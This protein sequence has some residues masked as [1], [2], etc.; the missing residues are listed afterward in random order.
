[1]RHSATKAR[2]LPQKKDWNA[3]M[4]SPPRIA[5]LLLAMAG[6]AAV[7]ALILGIG[8]A[9]DRH[10]APARGPVLGPDGMPVPIA[11]GAAPPLPPVGLSHTRLDLAA[12]FLLPAPVFKV[13]EP[14]FTA[15]GVIVLLYAGVRIA[16]RRLRGGKPGPGRMSRAEVVE[17]GPLLDLNQIQEQVERLARTIQAPAGALPTYGKSQDL[18]YAHI[19][20]DDAYHWIVVERGVE[21]QRRTTRDLDELLYWVFSA[22]TF[23]MTGAYTQEDRR[24]DQD[25][26]RLMFARHVALMEML[27][28]HWAIRQQAEIDEILARHP[29]NDPVG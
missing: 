10:A 23:S 24:R 4:R 27:R 25:P 7:F 29:F 21:L 9:L 1:M 22:V 16:Q 28:P 6:V 5:G 15:L 8:F 20:V 26:R 3:R 17:S 11:D 19:M 2:G 12:R 18:G 13:F 14:L